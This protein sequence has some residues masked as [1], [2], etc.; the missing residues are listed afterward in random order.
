M[1]RMFYWNYEKELIVIVSLVQPTQ[2][3]CT[4]SFKY[5][6][7]NFKADFLNCTFK[8]I[9][10]TTHLRLDPQISHDQ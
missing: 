2:Q 3:I 6:Y 7:T 1:A 4:C 10:P 9:L 8:S 5:F